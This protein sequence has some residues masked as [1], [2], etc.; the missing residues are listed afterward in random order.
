[1]TTL[2]CMKVSEWLLDSKRVAEPAL[3][4][5]TMP[6]KTKEQQTIQRKWLG[7]FGIKLP[8]FPHYQ[9]SRKKYCR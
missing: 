7:I 8:P 5:G 6:C 3:F 1:M 9:D 2:L 4:L